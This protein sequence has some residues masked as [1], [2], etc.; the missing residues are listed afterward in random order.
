MFANLFHED[1]RRRISSNVG[2]ANC[3][4]LMAE[5]TVPLYS[6]HIPTKPSVLGTQTMSVAQLLA[7]TGLTNP[8][9]FHAFQF[10]LY[11]ETK[12]VGY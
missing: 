6:L 3:S 5:L 8:V 12:G 11:S 10:F 1:T 4:V 9:I 2:I 7:S